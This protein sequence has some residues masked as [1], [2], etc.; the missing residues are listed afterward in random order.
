[1][2]IESMGRRITRWMVA[3]FLLS[4]AGLALADPPGP[5]ARLAYITGSTSFSPGGEQEWSRAVVN[6]PLIT[7]DKLWVDRGARAEL[8]LGSA[9][10]RIGSVSSVT[11]LNLNDRTTQLEL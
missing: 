3:A 7:G 8:Q 2:Q 4:L 9:A 6:R 11:L 5:V 10:V 1:M